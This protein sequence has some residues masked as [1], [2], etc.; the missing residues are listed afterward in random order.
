MTP[1]GS[2]IIEWIREGANRFLSDQTRKRI[3]SLIGQ[4]QSI[5][6]RILG[7]QSQLD[8]MTEEL[9]RVKAKLNHLEGEI[10]FRNYGTVLP[11]LGEGPDDSPPSHS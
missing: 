10:R 3:K 4:L 9:E 11:K 5:P 6:V 8:Q 2:K 7:I 1:H